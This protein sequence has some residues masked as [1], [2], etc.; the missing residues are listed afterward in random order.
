MVTN[1]SFLWIVTYNM[2]LPQ[3]RF[4]F[5]LRNLGN[6]EKPSIF[7]LQNSRKM[8]QKKILCMAALPCLSLAEQDR[9]KVIAHRGYWQSRGSAQ[10]SITSLLFSAKN[11]L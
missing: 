11:L 10:N 9:A 3:K 8:K 2:T 5:F 1:P 7:T 6:S 4:S